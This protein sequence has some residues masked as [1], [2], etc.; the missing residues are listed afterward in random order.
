[1]V[2]GILLP[3]IAI[4]PSENSLLFIILNNILA[5]HRELQLGTTGEALGWMK[6]TRT[7]FW[8]FESVK[9]L[10]SSVQVQAAALGQPHFGSC[11][12][13]KIKLDF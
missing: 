4:A 9:V 7:I 11:W 5:N 3:P 2:Q 12:F 13:D 10:T 8:S 1:M 6:V